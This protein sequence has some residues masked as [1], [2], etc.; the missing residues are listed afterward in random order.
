MKYILVRGASKAVPKIA[1]D[2]G[3]LYG[4]R[5]DHKPYDRVHMLDVNWKAYKWADVCNKVACYQPTMALVPDFEHPS[6]LGQILQR[7]AQ[8]Q[9]LG[10]PEILI[11][12]KF[13]EAIPVMPMSVIIAISVPAPDYA[14]YIPPLWQIQNRRV[15]LLGGIP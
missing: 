15:H 6:Q 4:T 1:S 10:V 12:P 7:I 13:E 8:L 14:G 2:G 5:H 11:C 9:D 3:W